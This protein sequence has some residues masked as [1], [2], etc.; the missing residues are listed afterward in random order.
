[1]ACR[2]AARWAWNCCCAFR[3][4]RHVFRATREV[5]EHH[6]ATRSEDGA[7]MRAL[8]RS[9]VGRGAKL[10]CPPS[11]LLQSRESKRRGVFSRTHARVD[12][13]A[14]PPL[15]QVCPGAPP[16][17]PPCLLCVMCS[18]SSK[19]MCYVN[20]SKLYLC[21]RLALNAQYGRLW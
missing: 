19:H 5:L 3:R 11:P 7:L 16:K 21:F 17:R 15:V 18:N 2:H 9:Q 4:T 8:L 14:P 1:M 12:Q 10:G 13:S 20:T 6:H